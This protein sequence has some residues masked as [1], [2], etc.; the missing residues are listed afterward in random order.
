MSLVLIHGFTGG[1]SS[2]DELFSHLDVPTSSLRPTLL[3]H[4]RDRDP[5]RE[6]QSFVE[7]VDRLGEEL[8]AGAPHTLV[9]YSLGGR[10]AAGLVARFPH[11]WSS[12]ILVGAHP[13]LE[14]AELDAREAL[15]RAIA[16]RLG[17]DIDAFVDYW[18]SLPIFAGQKERNPTGYAAQDTLRRSHRPNA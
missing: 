17:H 6:S 8:R 16:E 12:A 13:G 3:G 5:K 7:E 1:P 14:E 10:V 4:H 9:G 2:F 15:D 11:L 18:A